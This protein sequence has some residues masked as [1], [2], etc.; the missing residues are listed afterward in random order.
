MHHGSLTV[1]M[2]SALVPVARAAEAPKITAAVCFKPAVT[3]LKIT[4]DRWPDGTDL[5]QFGLDA[6]RIEGAKTDE[7]K[8]LAV[9]RWMRR[10]TM[11]TNG[12]APR[13]GRRWVD[14]SKILNVYGAHHCGGLSLL[15]TDIWRSIGYPARRLY[16]HGH[17]LGDLWYTDKDG[18][19][20]YHTFDNNYG[21]FVYT[22][23]GSRIAH[24]EDIGADF[25]IYDHPSR[26][27]VPWL[28]KKMWMWGWCHM[29]QMALP[30]PRTMDL[31]PGEGVVRLWG[32]HGKPHHDNVGVR[33]WDEKDQPTYKREFGNGVSTW[34]IDFGPDWRD[35]LAAQPVNAT[36]KNG[37][38]V[39]ADP[40]RPAEVVYRVWLPYIVADGQLLLKATGNVT[41]ET[42]H[43]KTWRTVKPG[44][45]YVK[46]GLT[47]TNGGPPG[48]YAYL[49]RLRLTDGAKVSQFAVADVVQLNSR[50]L[51]ALIAGENK[52]TVHGNLAEGYAVQVMYV[53][54][55]AHAKNRIHSAFLH[56]LPASYT[57]W[58]AGKSWKDVVCKK[59]ITRIKPTT[60]G[61][62]HVD[63]SLPP[64][65]RPDGP[66]PQADVR[67]IIGPKAAP[68]DRPAAAWIADLKSEDPA[69]RRAA[70]AAL[71]AQREAKAWDAL[72]TVALEDITQ[73]KMH[74]MQALFWIDRRKAVPILR[75]ILA[76]D[77]SVKFAEKDSE[78]GSPTHGNCVGTIAAMCGVTGFKELVPE[79]NALA[80]KTSTN[81][82]WGV[83]RALGRLNDPR[84]YPAIRRFCRSGNHD[85]GTISCKAAGRVLDPEAVTNASRWLRSKRYPIRTLNAIE[86]L[87]KAG[88]RGHT[89]VILE[90]LKLR[91]YSEDWRAGC[92]TAL[93]RVGD[94]QK[95]IPVVEGLLAKERYPW[96]RARLQAALAQLRRRARTP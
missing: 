92:A 80:W 83:I 7:E 37:A 79:L 25:S 78:F 58:A 31:R 90:H 42:D 56:R 16:R 15:L 70:A 96:V 18:V 72:V 17:T 39:Q 45:F 95:S 87:G 47:K 41:I 61:E 4:C 40:A 86:A 14:A 85:T 9:W 68:K 13:E 34:L 60:A 10:C 73:A 62:H 91:S 64:D 28:D 69:V 11:R 93:A 65:V 32:N 77:E 84:G 53:W 89:E 46:Q 12:R 82:R 36:V 1:L 22:R 35:S 21:W 3:D 52:I 88:V 30:K 76:K 50:S 44:E 20:R 71:S 49:L 51:P 81:A 8:A 6:I 54:G 5:R 66:L 43:G 57:I 55:D 26:T 33:P 94:P 75:K 38:L 2:L 27:H 74:A 29:P 19:G 23:D 63:K 24:A 48:R 67:T 59:I